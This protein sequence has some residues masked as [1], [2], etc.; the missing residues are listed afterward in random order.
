MKY[1]QGI[2]DLGF[3]EGRVKILKNIDLWVA[4]GMT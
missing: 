4:K 3:G 1:L 2:R